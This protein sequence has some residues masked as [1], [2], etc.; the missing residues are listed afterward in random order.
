MRVWCRHV[1]VIH[2]LVGE[3]VSRQSFQEGGQGEGGLLLD[4]DDLEVLGGGAEEGVQGLA[5]AQALVHQHFL[6]REE[7][8]KL[9]Q[10][11]LKRIA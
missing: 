9:L 5:L 8:N 3:E 4:V 10:T 2:L 6:I 7:G 1:C 11:K